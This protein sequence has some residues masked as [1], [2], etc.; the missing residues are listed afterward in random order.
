MVNNAGFSS[1]ELRPV[2]IY[3]SKMMFIFYFIR[4]QLAGIVTK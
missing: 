1:A 2:D 3:N 4:S